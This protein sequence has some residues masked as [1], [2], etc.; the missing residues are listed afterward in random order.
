MLQ[1][2]RL[3]G[4]GH[5]FAIEQERKQISID[6]MKLINSNFTINYCLCN[7]YFIFA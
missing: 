5:D 4:V 2:M 6:L 7:F 1:S 3:Q